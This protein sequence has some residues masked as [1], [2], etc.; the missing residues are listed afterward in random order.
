MKRTTGL[1]GLARA[2]SPWS[3]PLVAPTSVAPPS[4]LALAADPISGSP[5]LRVL[6]T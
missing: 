5:R 3:L 6:P 4:D 2:A 1:S